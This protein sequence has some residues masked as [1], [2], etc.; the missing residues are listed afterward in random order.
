M[1]QLT[2]E[3]EYLRDNFV[4]GMLEVQQKTG[5]KNMLLQKKVQALVEILESKDVMLSEL[6]AATNMK[7]QMIN[8]KLEVNMK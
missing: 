8:R 7:P 4:R 1:F 2:A 6:V 5:L 3:R